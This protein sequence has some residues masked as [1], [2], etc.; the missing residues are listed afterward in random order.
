VHLHQS[1]Q[2]VDKKKDAS[3]VT[4]IVVVGVILH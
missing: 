2:F 1:S 3:Q 4:A